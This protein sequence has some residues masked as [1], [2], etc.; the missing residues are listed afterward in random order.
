VDDGD[1]VFFSDAVAA[2]AAAAAIDGVCLPQLALL[3]N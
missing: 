3:V 2:A 1:D